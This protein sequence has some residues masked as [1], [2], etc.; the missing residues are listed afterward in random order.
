MRKCPLCDSGNTSIGYGY[1]AGHHCLAGYEFC[2]DC[3]ELID[4]Q[5]D[6]DGMPEERIASIKAEHQKWRDKL[7]A[8]I[9]ARGEG[10]A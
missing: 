2:D 9:K 3:D 6:Y 1:G 7:D 5:P 4:L 10:Q 8:K